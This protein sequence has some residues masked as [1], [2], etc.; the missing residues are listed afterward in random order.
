[1]RG[2]CVG[3][4]ALVGVG[5]GVGAGVA[6]VVVVVGWC[7]RCEASGVKCTS[8]LAA[9]SLAAVLASCALHSRSAATAS[10]TH[11]LTHTRTPC[12]P[13]VHSEYCET[14]EDF[15]ARRTRLAFLDKLACEQALPKVGGGRV[16][17]LLSQLLLLRFCGSCCRRCC[18]VGIASVNPMTGHNTAMGPSAR[19]PPVAGGGAD[20]GGE[21]VEPAAGG[22]RA[23]AGARLPEDL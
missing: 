22:G 8:R 21:G 11:S 1:M 15:I 13:A 3:D 12:L 4:T 9:L 18:G 7:G 10:G 6:L 2:L 20:G 16:G 17:R 14:P 23:A 19:L 5:V